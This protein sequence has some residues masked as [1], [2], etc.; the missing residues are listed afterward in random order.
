MEHDTLLEDDLDLT[1]QY[2]RLRGQH[3]YYQHVLDNYC[4]Y[5]RLAPIL[6]QFSSL[7]SG[8]I[9]DL[10][11]GLNAIRSKLERLSLE[12]TAPEHTQAIAQAKVFCDVCGWRIYAL[13]EIS[14]SPPIHPEPVNLPEWI[15]RLLDALA[16]WHSPSIQIKFDTTV[17]RLIVA[18]YDNALRLALLEP[19]LNAFQALPDGGRVSVSLQKL[20]N[21]LAQIEITDTGPGLPPRDPEECFDL[22]FT[23]DLY[24]Y[25]LGLYVARKVVEKHR[26]TFVLQS[27][28]DQGTRVVI[29]LPIGNPEPDWDD[30]ST[31]VLELEDLHD[32]IADQKQK[33]EACQATYDL[34]RE[35]MLTRL[36][37]LFGQLCASTVQFLETGLD[38]V[39]HTLTPLSGQLPDESADHIQFI[40]EKCDYC[41]ILLGNARALN[42]DFDIKLASTDLNQVTAKAVQL[43]A[44]RAQPGTQLHLTQ[45]D[46][47]PLVQAN[48]SLIATALVNLLRNAL[49]AARQNGHVDVQTSSTNNDVTIWLTNTGDTIP[50]GARTHIFDLDYTTRQN[51]DFGLG[52]YAAHF[53]IT[54]FGGCITVPDRPHTPTRLEITLSKCGGETK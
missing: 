10:G 50:L 2:Y 5:G 14:P 34:P 35:E 54:K 19:L 7:C 16:V 29:Q 45:A 23:T 11:N 13:G 47:L 48:A 44:W 20:D 17:P 39:R 42:P 28:S 37:N 33:I 41:D 40:L 9:H 53:I 24:C 18:D 38:S 32:A 6:E 30:E 3:I 49:D 1:S 4:R 22:H 26:G 25:G 8:F 27:K 51:R 21:G 46:S 15:P 52:L 12:E 36:S 43:M 31:L